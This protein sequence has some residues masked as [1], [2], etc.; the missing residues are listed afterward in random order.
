MSLLLILTVYFIPAI[1]AS[2]RRH[3]QRLAIDVL[4]VF[5]G[6]TLIGWVV[7]LVWA[8]TADVLP[9]SSVPTAFRKPITFGESMQRL[10][11][12]VGGVAAVLLVL[13]ALNSIGHAQQTTVRDS[14]GRTVGTI[15]TDSAGTQ[16]F[17][18]SNG[19]TTGTSTR[20]SA[21]TTT[22]RDSQG[23]TTGTVQRGR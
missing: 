1:I 5:L 11:M 9:K 12:L 16:T 2:V 3:R 22:F 21:G 20:D 8:C 18:D 6:W 14:S 19:N 7:A 17:R 4:N 23:R 13:A 15:T 10:G